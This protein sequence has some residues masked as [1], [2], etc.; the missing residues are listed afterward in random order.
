M[1]TT[2]HHKCGYL[3]NFYDIGLQNADSITTLRI[4]QNSYRTG[5]TIDDSFFSQISSYIKNDVTVH[6]NI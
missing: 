6:K 2:R 3:L 1:Y 5:L 4:G